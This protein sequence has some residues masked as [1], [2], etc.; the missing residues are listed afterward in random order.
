[1][2]KN[3][4]GSN[5]DNNNSSVNRIAL[6]DESQLEDI[7]K[8]SSEKPVLIF[9]HSSRCGISSMVLKRFENKISNEEKD[10]YL[11]DILNYR[12][13]S[14]LIAGKFQIQ[15]QSPQLLVIKE[16]QVF[17]NDSHFGVLDVNLEG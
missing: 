2:F 17:A 13:I 12:N 8:I 3:I 11:L 7:I 14:N 9:K 5:K 6:T 16:G 10:Y 4:F 1:M 15:H